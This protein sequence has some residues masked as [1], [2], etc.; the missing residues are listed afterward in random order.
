MK[1]FFTLLSVVFAFVCMVSCSSSST[2]SAVVEKYA[3]CM[4]NEDYETAVDLFYF[5]VDDA[6]K[7]KTNKEKMVK[8]FDRYVKPEF[9]K[10]GGVKGYEIGEEVISEDGLSAT[11]SFDYIYG[12]DKVDSQRSKLKNIDGK[13]YLD[14]GK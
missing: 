5:S 3:K 2:P 6:E 8:M 10:N 7:L 1:K 12:N 11:V 14:S 4:M 13:W 9:D